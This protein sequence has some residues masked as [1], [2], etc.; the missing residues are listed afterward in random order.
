MIHHTEYMKNSAALHR[1]YYAQFVSEVTLRQV[2]MTIG[3]DDIKS[4]TDK[5]MNDI[6][7]RRWDRLAATLHLARKPQELGEVNSHAVRV[8]VAK[9]AARQ[10]KERLYGI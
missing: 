6:P 7:L 5:Y 9:E 10:I 2:E 1:E 4:S 8:C 3:V